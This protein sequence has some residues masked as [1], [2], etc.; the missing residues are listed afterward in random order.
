MSLI[1]KI[2]F[3]CA[4]I[5]GDFMYPFFKW[6]CIIVCIAVAEICLYANFAV[7][8]I[9]TGIE[10]LPLWPT[11]L[12]WLSM[13]LNTHWWLWLAIPVGVAILV[14]FVFAGI[15]LE[16]TKTFIH[17]VVGGWLGG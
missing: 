12:L 3:Q 8:P 9:A 11:L 7:A 14:G 1:G 15:C 6:S 13:I 2:A 4:Y 17:T 10:H 5:E 16:I